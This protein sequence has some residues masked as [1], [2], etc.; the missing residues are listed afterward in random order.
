LSPVDSPVHKTFARQMSV[1][2]NKMI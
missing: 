2:G 1:Q